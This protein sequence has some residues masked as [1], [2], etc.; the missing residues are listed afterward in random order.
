MD[1]TI[2]NCLKFIFFYFRIYE[3]IEF[4]VN[5]ENKY[6]TGFNCL[7]EIANYIGLLLKLRKL[8]ALSCVTSICLKL[9]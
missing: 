6:Y 5:V 2:L 9:G 1:V 3:V 4:Q 7:K 8:H